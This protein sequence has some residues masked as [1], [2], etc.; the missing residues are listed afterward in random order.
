MDGL[1]VG[2]V[3]N[4]VLRDRQHLAEDGI[5]I[6]V[7]TLERYSAISFFPDRT[8]CPVDLSMC[9][10][11]R[12]S[13]K[14]PREIVQTAMERTALLTHVTD[15]GKMKTRDPRYPWRISLEAHEAPP[16]DSSD[17]YGVE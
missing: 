4:I 8:S 11:Q 14:R 12:I 9:V 10:R 16:D 17:H 7:L 3:G 1:G 13:W 5:V 2:D 15:W 6:A